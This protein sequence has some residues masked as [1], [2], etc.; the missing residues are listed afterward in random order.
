[1][2]QNTIYISTTLPI[3]ELIRRNIGDADEILLGQDFEQKKP[4]YQNIKISS[5]ATPFGRYKDWYFHINPTHTSEP[6]LEL[7]SLVG[8]H[9]NIKKHI[10]FIKSINRARIEFLAKN[11]WLAIKGI[12]PSFARSLNLRKITFEEWTNGKKIDGG[13]KSINKALYGKKA[14]FSFTEVD[15]SDNPYL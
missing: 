6:I 5:K 9:G 2:I 3:S 12:G 8:I 7:S 15:L 14:S 4:K 10:E 1:M 13:H 11:K